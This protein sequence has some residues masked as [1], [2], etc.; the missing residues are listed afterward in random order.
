MPGELEPETTDQAAR[1]A[2]NSIRLGTM[3]RT[4]RSGKQEEIRVDLCRHSGKF[5]A[6]VRSWLA[7]YKSENFQPQSGRGINLCV[8]DIPAIIEA[9]AAAYELAMTH[10]DAPEALGLVDVAPPPPPKPAPP[11]L[12]AISPTV[13]DRMERRLAAQAEAEHDELE[14]RA[15][16]V[17]AVQDRMAARTE[18]EREEQER[19]EAGVRAVQDRM[20]ARAASGPRPERVRE[21]VELEPEENFRP[22]EEGDG[23]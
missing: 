18:A 4:I 19:R 22:E 17:R 7:S 14:R 15:A 12:R 1:P 8:S 3:A 9:L 5:Y 23:S 21:V 16:I 2:K 6:S 20:A 11:R 10:A 13:Q